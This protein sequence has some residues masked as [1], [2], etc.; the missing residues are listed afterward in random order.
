MQNNEI[1]INGKILSGNKPDSLSSTDIKKQL[2]NDYKFTWTQ[3]I[4]TIFW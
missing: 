1:D 3:K 4:S 2:E